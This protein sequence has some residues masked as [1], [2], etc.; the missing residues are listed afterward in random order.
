MGYWGPEP[1]KQPLYSLSSESGKLCSTH[2]KR[3]H[4]AIYHFPSSLASNLDYISHG[5]AGTCG[6]L[7][8]GRGFWL[9]Q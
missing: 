8:V 1:W 4:L 3:N 9:E 6:R 2:T 7:T 5:Y